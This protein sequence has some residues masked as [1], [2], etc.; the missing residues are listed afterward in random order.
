MDALLGSR[1]AT[2]VG[3]VPDARRVLRGGFALWRVLM[4]CW[5][6]ENWIVDASGWLALLSGWLSA[7]LFRPG[8]CLVGSGR[9]FCDRLV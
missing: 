3:G 2:L 4:V 1:T 8:P 5:W 6:F 9:S 7:V